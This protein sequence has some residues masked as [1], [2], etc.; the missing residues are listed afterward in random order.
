MERRLGGS[1]TRQMHVWE[2]WHGPVSFGCC[3][4]RTPKVGSASWTVHTVFHSRIRLGLSAGSFLT[5]D[6]L[7]SAVAVAEPLHFFRDPS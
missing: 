5:S 2:H 3:N 7:K 1:K 4:V 6:P